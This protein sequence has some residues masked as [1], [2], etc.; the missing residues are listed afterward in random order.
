ML[1]KRLTKLEEKNVENW[2]N[3][4]K[5]YSGQGNNDEARKAALKA[6]QIDPSVKEYAD[7]FINGLK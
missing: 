7:K 5:L 1:Y 3:L 6:I 2:I 4:A